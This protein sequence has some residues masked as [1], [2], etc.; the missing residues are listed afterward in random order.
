MREFHYRQSSQLRM[1]RPLCSE[2]GARMWLTLI[3]PADDPNFDARTFECLLCDHLQT[4]LVAIKP[5]LK[6]PPPQYAA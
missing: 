3:E 5:T 6:K 1:D 4:V 2:C